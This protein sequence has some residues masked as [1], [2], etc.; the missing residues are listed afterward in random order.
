MTVSPHA[1]YRWTITC[2]HTAVRS[3]PE[4]TNSNAKGMEGPSNCDSGLHDNPTQFSMYDDDDNCYY[5]GMLY[6][7][8]DGFEPLDDFGTPN[9]GATSIKINGKLL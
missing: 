1:C 4:G 2:D 3:L 8:F 6:G 9:A 5:E 7:D